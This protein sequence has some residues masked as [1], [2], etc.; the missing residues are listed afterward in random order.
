MNLGGWGVVEKK[1]EE[2]GGTRGEEV[3]LLA[4]AIRDEAAFLSPNPS[5]L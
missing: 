4:T 3:T 2:E 5:W 1:R